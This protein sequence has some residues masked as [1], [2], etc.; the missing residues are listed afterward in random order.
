[1]AMR[2]RPTSDLIV[3]FLAGVVG[4]VIIFST[5]GLAFGYAIGRSPDV[6]TIAK[7]IADLTSSLIALIVGY[8]AGRGVNGNGGGGGP[9]PP[10]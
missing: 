1:M 2:D 3:L 9:K 6:G 10:E 8:V 4:F 5:I 7:A